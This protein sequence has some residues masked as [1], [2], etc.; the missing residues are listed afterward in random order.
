MQERVLVE[1]VISYYAQ[2][3]GLRD[4]RLESYQEEPGSLNAGCNLALWRYAD[5][6]SFINSVF[7]INRS[8]GAFQLNGAAT[9]TGG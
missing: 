3:A 2:L 8:S 7:L 9:I 1:L 6:G 4:G 5:N